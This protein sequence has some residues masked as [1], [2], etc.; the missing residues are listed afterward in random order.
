MSISKAVTLASVGIA[1]LMA[2]EAHKEMV[3]SVSAGQKMIRSLV[4]TMGA[5]VAHWHQR[6]GVQMCA[7]LK[8][9]NCSLE[10]VPSATHR[11][12]VG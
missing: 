12:E 3:M 2:V 7:V 9:S 4:G 6:E 8:S 10:R 5:Q 1:V 11:M